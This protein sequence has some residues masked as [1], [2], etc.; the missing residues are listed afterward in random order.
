MKN[1]IQSSLRYEIAASRDFPDHW[2]VEAIDPDGCVFVAIFSGP[3]ARERAAEY[4]DWKNGV[5]HSAAV[6]QLVRR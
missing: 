2:N 5:R 6:L 1:Y 4:A 3:D